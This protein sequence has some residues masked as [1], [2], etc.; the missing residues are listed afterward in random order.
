MKHKKPFSCTIAIVA[1]VVAPC[2]TWTEPGKFVAY[3]EHV[4]N[5]SFNAR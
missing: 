2:P 1:V 3:E 5:K 4:L